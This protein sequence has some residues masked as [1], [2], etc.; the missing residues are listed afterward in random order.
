MPSGRARCSDRVPN[1]STFDCISDISCLSYSV[2]SSAIIA[3]LRE[4]EAAC[5]ASFDMLVKTA[6]S[7]STTVSG[8]SAFVKELT[9]GIE[10]V[11]SAV[12]PLIEQKKYLRNFLDKAAA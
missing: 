3:Q 10:S 7:S 12:Q 6:W 2:A 4:L 1:I 8:P 11:A 5:D 9:K